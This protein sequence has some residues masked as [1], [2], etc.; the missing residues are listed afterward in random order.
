MQN[1]SSKSYIIFAFWEKRISFILYLVYFVD[2]ADA[3]AF[4]QMEFI[5]TGYLIVDSWPFHQT[6]WSDKMRDR[7]QITRTKYQAIKIKKSKVWLEFDPHVQH[8]QLKLKTAFQ[9]KFRYF[10]VKRHWFKLRVRILWSYSF[11]NMDLITNANAEMEVSSNKLEHCMKCISYSF[12]C[13]F[14]CNLEKMW[15]KRIPWIL[16]ELWEK[17]K[18]SSKEERNSNESTVGLKKSSNAGY[19]Q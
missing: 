4:V 1:F 9:M 15:I 8:N 10:L 3:L 12:G 14:P 6:S 13:F 19:K 16:V 18:I 2:F 17:T 5:C 11:I 7:Q